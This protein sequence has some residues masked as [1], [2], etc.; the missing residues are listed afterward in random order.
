MAGIEPSRLTLK[1][2]FV[3]VRRLIK[4]N[5]PTTLQYSFSTPLLTLSLTVGWVPSR[6]AALL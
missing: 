1:A 2:I 3:D 4:R 5:R 6:Q